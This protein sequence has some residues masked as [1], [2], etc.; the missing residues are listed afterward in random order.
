MADAVAGSLGTL[1]ASPPPPPTSTQKYTTTRYT[2]HS[3]TD[4][5]HLT[6]FVVGKLYF[7][8]LQ[9]LKFPLLVLVFLILDVFLFVFLQRY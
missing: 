6:V 8:R 9:V 2:T 7:Y 3:P 5:P 1:A 4:I